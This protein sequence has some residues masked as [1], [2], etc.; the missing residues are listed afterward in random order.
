MWS[1]QWWQDHDFQKSF[2]CCFCCCCCWRLFFQERSEGI[3]LII[4]QA[5]NLQDIRSKSL[6]RS[7]K[8][9]REER[10]KEIGQTIERIEVTML[11]LLLLLPPLYMEI[12]SFSMT[13]FPI[14]TSSTT[15][16]PTFSLSLPLYSFCFLFFQFFL[17]I[18]F[19][20]FLNLSQ[21]TPIFFYHSISFSYY[22]NLSLSFFFLFS[23]FSF[24][25][26]ITPIP[27]LL[28]LSFQSHFS[29]F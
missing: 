27:T 13:F 23:T 5:R 18:S 22:F 26:S 10:L 17:S 11:L 2:S 6:L 9:M 21:C 1:P 24:N 19:F 8:W 16:R 7:T 28:T 12:S 29:P 4:T 14:C 15:Q 20:T 25:L 3:F